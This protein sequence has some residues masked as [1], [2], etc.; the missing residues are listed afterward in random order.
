[1]DSD[2]AVSLLTNVSQMPNQSNVKDV[3]KALDYQSLALACAAWYVYSVRSRGL[4]HFNWKTYLD[5]LNRGKDE[6]MGDIKRK[7]D[8]GYTKSMSVAVRMA[9]EREVVDEAVLLQTF[10]F[11]SICAPGPIPLEVVV[12][13][14]AKRTPDLINWTRRT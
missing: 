14:V 8:S 1:M 4:S 11:L 9:V 3:A 12:N 5:K 10:Q 6:V 2:D 13:F 7:C